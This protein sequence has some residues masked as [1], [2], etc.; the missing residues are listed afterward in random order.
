MPDKILSLETPAEQRIIW[1]KPK[2]LTQDDAAQSPHVG[3]PCQGNC[4]EAQMHHYAL[5][6]RYRCLSPEEGQG[7]RPLESGGCK[8]ARGPREWTREKEREDQ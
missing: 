5:N 1:E 4:G 2:P 6:A 8:E 3:R 7:Q